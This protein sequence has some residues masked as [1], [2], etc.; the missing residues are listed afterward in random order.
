MSLSPSTALQSPVKRW[1][2]QQGTATT[3][4]PVPEGEGHTGTE[5]PA[6][7]GRRCGL[8]P[9]FTGVSHQ[10]EGLLPLQMHVCGGGRAF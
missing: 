8:T 1:L 9:P 7:L 6:N 2:Y 4:L 5:L 10:K 3:V